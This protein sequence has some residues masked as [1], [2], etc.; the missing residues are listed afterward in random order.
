MHSRLIVLVVAALVAAALPS[1][2]AAGVGEDFPGAN[3]AGP[4]ACSVNGVQSDDADASKRTVD[5]WVFCNYLVTS[6]AVK[7]SKPIRS[8]TAPEL[9]GADPSTDSLGCERSKSKRISCSGDVG[10][11]VRIEIPVELRKPMC[12][13][14]KLRLNLRAV[15]SP[16]C[17]PGFACTLELYSTQTPSP[18]L[19]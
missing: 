14:P 12:E 3:V 15:G 13:R 19:C 5:V 18:K 6:L 1:A 11:G 2:A 10:A 17:P 4:P 9:Y 8:V 16:P 7:T